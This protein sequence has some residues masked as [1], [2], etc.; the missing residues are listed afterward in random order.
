MAKLRMIQGLRKKL[1]PASARKLATRQ[2]AGEAYGRHLP[3]HE[4][5]RRIAKRKLDVRLGKLL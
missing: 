4:I 5:K 1:L 3:E 2:I